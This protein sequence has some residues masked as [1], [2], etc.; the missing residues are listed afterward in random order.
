ALDFEAQSA[1]Y[2]QY[3]H[4]RCCGILADVTVPETVDAGVLDHPAEI[5]LLRTIARFPERVENAAERRRPHVIA[6]YTREFAETFNAFYR[7]CPVL[8]AE[9]DRRAARIALVAAA[10]QTIANALALLGVPAPE[11]M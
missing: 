1:P 10:R 7:E 11:S 3:V 4:A 8:D 6:A 5:D 2:V 9:G